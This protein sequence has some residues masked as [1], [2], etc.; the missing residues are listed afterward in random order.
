MTAPVVAH[1]TV[2]VGANDGTVYGVSAA[3]GRQRWSGTAGP[4]IVGPAEGIAMAIGGGL[5]VVPAGN[6][7]TAFGN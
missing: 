1:G 5:L 3:T 7:L 6:V 2:F 4:Q